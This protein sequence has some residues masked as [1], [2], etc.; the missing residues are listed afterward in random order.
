M[1][2]HKGEWKEACLLG[3]VKPQVGGTK[4]YLIMSPEYLDVLS[5]RMLYGGF[6]SGGILWKK[7]LTPM[8]E[9]EAVS[10]STGEGLFAS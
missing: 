9:K 1:R 5:I 6:P 7:G 3:S 8:N 2:K 10:I 4:K